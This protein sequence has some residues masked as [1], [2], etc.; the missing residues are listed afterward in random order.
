MDTQ[1]NP[2]KPAASL[3]LFA[4]VVTMASGIWVSSIEIGVNGSE[5]A[6]TN[7]LR[8]CLMAGLCYGMWR[9]LAWARWVLVVLTSLSMVYSLIGAIASGQSALWSLVT[10]DIFVL[11]VI[12]LDKSVGHFVKAQGEQKEKEKKDKGSS[13]S[14]EENEGKE[15]DEESSS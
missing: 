4:F 10:A 15:S 8:L 3:L 5:A 7:G 13:E 9:G 14:Q 2:H 1:P 11:Y 6:W 12:A